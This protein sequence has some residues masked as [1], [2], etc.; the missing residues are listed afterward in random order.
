MLHCVKTL[1]LSLLGACSLLA[2]NFMPLQPGNSWTYRD[3]QSGQSFTVRVGTPVM[4]NYQVYY[5]L[6]GFTNDRLLVRIDEKGELVYLDEAREQERL[7]TSFQPFEGGWWQGGARACDALGQT[8][9]KRG[10]HDGP[11]GPFQDV[12]QVRFRNFDC[13]DAGTDSEQYAENIGMVRRSETWIGGV[14]T[15]DLVYARVGSQI[16]DVLPNTSF[17]VTAD[18]SKG[19]EFLKVTFRLQER[20]SSALK[21]T[22][23]TSQEYEVRLRDKDGKVLWSW[24]ADKMFTQNLHERFVSTEWSN[25]VSIPRPTSTGSEPQPGNYSVQVW[26][27]TLGTTPEFA[28]TVPLVITPNQVN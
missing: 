17:R 12:L 19:S 1:T 20:A 23:P 9:E 8:L 24:S 22:F 26:L 25:T 13:A 21:L 2:G 11:A 15:Y 18:Y 27:T 5:S 7:L 14:R 3:A 4:S 28:A 6:N 16:I 10:I